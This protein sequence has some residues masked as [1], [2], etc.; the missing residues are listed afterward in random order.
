MKII[1]WDNNKYEHDEAFGKLVIPMKHLFGYLR[2]ISAYKN[3]SRSTRKLVSNLS[4]VF[5]KCRS[6]S[7]TSR[8]R[9]ENCIRCKRNSNLR[10]Y[11]VKTKIYSLHFF[12]SSDLQ[13]EVIL[14]LSDYKE[15]IDE[16]MEE[17]LTLVKLI[18]KVTNE[19]ETVAAILVKIFQACGEKALFLVKS[20]V[21]QEIDSTRILSF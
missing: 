17:K 7:S 14:P 2:S 11:S 13:E 19:R 12:F 16:L 3:R 4:S 9:N 5:Y 8:R 21:S 20:L 18:S 6:F 10:I 15:L 1:I